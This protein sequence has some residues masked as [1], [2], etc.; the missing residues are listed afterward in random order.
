MYKRQVRSLVG[1]QGENSIQNLY[2]LADNRVEAIEFSVRE[3]S[4][5]VGIPLK[6]LHMKKGVL[7]LYILR[8]NTL[9]MPGGKDTILP[10]DRVIIITTQQYLDDIDKIINFDFFNGEKI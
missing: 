1:S 7:I 8:N 3:F 10:N 2:R 5:V 9:I 4:Q 6:D